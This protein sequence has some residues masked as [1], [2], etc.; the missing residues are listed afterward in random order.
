MFPFFVQI[1]VSVEYRLG[2]LSA[3]RADWVG[4]NAGAF[5]GTWGGTG[6]HYGAVPDA[7]VVDFS[8]NNV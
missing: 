5:K 4:V 7:H 1:P 2:A 3:V 8:G 6:T